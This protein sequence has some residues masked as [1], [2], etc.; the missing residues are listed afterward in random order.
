MASPHSLTM[1]RSSC[2]LTGSTSGRSLL[3]V[4]A[5][6]RAQCLLRCL[7]HFSIV[8]CLHLACTPQEAQERTDTL[9]GCI[10]TQLIM[11][12]V[13]ITYAA[14]QTA[15]SK[16][17]GLSSVQAPLR[18]LVL[19]RASRNPLIHAHKS[20]CCSSFAILSFLSRP[21]WS[22]SLSRIQFCSSRRTSCSLSFA[23]LVGP[24][25]LHRRNTSNHIDCQPCDQ[26]NSAPA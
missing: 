24:S 21:T 25:Q 20:T 11:I 26:P 7:D 6:L 2:F 19:M 8:T 23:D 4:V 3:V 12:S 10:L 1:R 18:Y 17:N 5:S 9:I 16:A 22:Y 14:T 13:V 15:L